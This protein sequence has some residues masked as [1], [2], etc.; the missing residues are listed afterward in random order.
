MKAVVLEIRNR[1]AAVLTNG[2]QI[3]KVNN[4]DFMVGQEINI[5]DAS[6][7]IYDMAK[8]AAKWMPAA[9]AAAFLVLVGRFTSVANEPYGVVSL[10]VNPSIEFTINN[11]D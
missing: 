8:S 7:R 6:E 3:I 11:R 9:V 5:M 4:N 2:G 10:D 1:K